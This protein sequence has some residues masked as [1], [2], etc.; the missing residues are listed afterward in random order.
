MAA[1]RIEREI[2][3]DAPPAVVWNLLTDPAQVAQWWSS[4]A[5]FEARPGAEGRLILTS[6]RTSE[7][8]EILIR[9]VRVE[10]EHRFAFRW[11]YPAGSEPEPGTA[12]LVEFT[13]VPEG[14]GTRLFLVES[15]IDSLARP[16]ADRDAYYTS[17]NAGWDIHLGHLRQF[18]EHGISPTP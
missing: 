6:R 13:L 16:D 11:D 7:S 8:M 5:E 18:A 14:A 17:H 3:I 2:L 15:G 1:D 10:P 4:E 9:V 12:P